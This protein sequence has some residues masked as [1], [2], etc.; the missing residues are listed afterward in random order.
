MSRPEFFAFLTDF[1]PILYPLRY[2]LILGTMGKT[3]DQR[4]EKINNKN[5]LSKMTRG[6][7]IQKIGKVSKDFVKKTKKIINFKLFAFL[8][9]FDL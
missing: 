3:T 6:K 1:G 7:E 5:R 9:F 8:T 2:I 4:T